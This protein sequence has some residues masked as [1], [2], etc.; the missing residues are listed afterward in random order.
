MIDIPVSIRL[1]GE[2]YQCFRTAIAITVGD[3]TVPAG[4]WAVVC[5]DDARSMSH[6]QFTAY[7]REACLAA[8]FPEA[9]VT[10]VAN[11]DPSRPDRA[12]PQV[13]PDR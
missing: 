13:E 9:F 8:G 11:H 6:E 2:E 4:H 3:V 10:S 12:D 1:D 7:Y 5:G